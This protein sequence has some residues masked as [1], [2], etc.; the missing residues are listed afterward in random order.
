VAK[1]LP[2]SP[3]EAAGL[4][5]GDII[6]KFN[7][8]TINLSSDLP[9]QVGRIIPGSNVQLDIVRAGKN[10]MVR[11]NIGTLS[12]GDVSLKS[13]GRM[14]SKPESNRLNVV[15]SELTDQQKNK[16]NLRNGIAI[17]KVLNG[18]GANA[19]L[20]AG[21]IV[22][23]LNGKRIKSVKQFVSLVN[24]LPEGRSVPM[25]IVRRGSPLFIPLKL[26]KQ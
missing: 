15:V 14:P 11:A 16:W 21:D 26:G 1:V 6:L 18:A 23:M 24:V 7:G 2:D 9:H 4:Q 12:N 25:R 17:E 19:G 20:V 13:S 8:Q 22:T 3:A 5:D 10:V